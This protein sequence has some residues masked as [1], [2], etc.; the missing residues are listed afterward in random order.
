MTKVF[1]FTRFTK[2]QLQVIA[3][4]SGLR[5]N[6]APISIAEIRG[7]LS[8]VEF[9]RMRVALLRSGVTDSD[10][11]D[12]LIEPGQEGEYSGEDDNDDDFEFDGVTDVT[13]KKKPVVAAEYFSLPVK[14][15]PK[16]A[17]SA[18]ASAPAPAQN[19]DAV[20]AALAALMSQG[21][22]SEA[23]VI[24]LASIAAGQMG[25]RVAD[26]M[27]A[28][29]AQ[30][31][32]DMQKMMAKVEADVKKALSNQPTVTIVQPAIGEPKKIAGLVHSR[33]ERVY[34]LA[35]LRQNVMLV[36]P[37]GCG[38]TQLAEQVAEALG[39]SFNFLSC[40]AGMSE[41]QLQGWLLPT[42][43]DGKFNY[44]PA[45]FVNTYE[46]GGVFLLDEMD[47]ADENL[48]LVINSALA[49]G[50]FAIPQRFENP[51][52]KRH[53]DFVMIGATNTY[54]N[55][56][57][58]VYAGRNQLDGA[59]LDRF[60]TGVTTMDYCPNVESA[61]V[62]STV[63]QWGAAIR[64]KINACKLRRVMSTRVLLGYTAQKNAGF[65]MAD[66][67]ESY[68]ADWSRDE[69]TKVGR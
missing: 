13:D 15:T 65:T 8:L 51:T 50:K 63:L 42:G 20:A 54:G 66:W 5:K 36:G 64:S 2:K 49:N 37:A 38:K 24:E 44:V 10:I 21:G 56:A 31:Q 4:E 60:R 14:A 55:G 16:I 68:F 1:D 22:V 18:P 58:R 62:D 69:L 27:S 12:L 57:D 9:G 23:R 17:L 48:L 35:S 46:N 59:T 25:E 39:L 32:A 29:E 41:S 19:I 34:K 33:F 45:A 53:A 52:A 6:W 11:D 28:N 47:A 40:S 26:Q 67:E 43:D 30:A 3:T 61:L 7:M